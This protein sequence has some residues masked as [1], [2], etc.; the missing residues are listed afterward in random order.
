MLSKILSYAIAVMEENQ[1]M[2]IIV[3]CPTAGACGI[4]PACIVAIAEEYN[5]DESS[6]ISALLTAAGIGKLVAQKVALAGA[7]AG[8]Q[9]ECG[10]AS[11][12]AAGAVVQM[13]GG[14]NHQ[15]INACALTLKNLLGLACDPIAGLVEVPCIK[16][17]GFIAIHAICAAEL[18]LA[19]VDSVVP[20]DE[21]VKAMSQIGDLMSPLLKETSEAGL[22]RSTTGK[23]I[24]NELI[25]K[26]H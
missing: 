17:N 25:Q 20:F 14:T 19:G 24:S 13:M 1:R 12:M 3:A 4:V 26:W 21:V 9:A 11:A 16:R 10:V 18:S 15:I 22:A 2:G 23:R 8:C 5:M 6:Q 7:V